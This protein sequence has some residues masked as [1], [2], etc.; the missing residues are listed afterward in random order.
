MKW[1]TPRSSFPS[2]FNNRFKFWIS[3]PGIES[4]LSRFKSF[5]NI[6]KSGT[7]DGVLY[8]TLFT[9]CTKNFLS[10]Y[11]HMGYDTYHVRDISNYFLTCDTRYDNTFFGFHITLSTLNADWIS[12]LFPVS[13]LLSKSYISLVYK[14]F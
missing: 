6:F 8:K 4:K 5:S 2:I 14:H 7:W 1:N 13:N 11:M 9:F 10:F 3:I 12:G